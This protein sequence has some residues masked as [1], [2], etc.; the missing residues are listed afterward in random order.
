MQAA[1]ILIGA[2]LLPAGAYI[3]FHIWRPVK[4]MPDEDLEGYLVRL[5]IWPPLGLLT[6]VALIGAGLVD[7][8]AGWWGVALAVALEAVLVGI[9]RRQK[10]RRT[11]T[12]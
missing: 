7:A 8:D 2:A 10:A 9:A 11:G 1:M 3:A 12:D 6:P 4:R 5:F